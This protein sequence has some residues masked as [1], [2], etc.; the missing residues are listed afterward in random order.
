CGGRALPKI[1]T[2]PAEVPLSIFPWCHLFSLHTAFLSLSLCLCH[3][4]THTQTQSHTHTHTHTHTRT[5]THTHTH[6]H[7]KTQCTDIHLGKNKA[8]VMEFKP[9][10]MR[11]GINN[12]MLPQHRKSL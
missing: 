7:N 8:K 6:T 10:P 4:H 5:H 3:T 1:K 9:H 12:S 2:S 11:T